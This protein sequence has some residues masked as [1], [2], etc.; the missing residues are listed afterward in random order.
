M[1]DASGG[2]N[3]N[4]TGW[5]YFTTSSSNRIIAGDDVSGLNLNIY[6]NP[7]KGIFN[8]SFVS[9]E[10]DNFEITITDAFGKMIFHED[11]QEFIGEYTQK[12]DLS[13]SPRGIYMV[14]I[15]TQGSFVSK[16][17]VLQ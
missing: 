1:C 13:N 6:P 10:V 7:T 15:K 16:R 14:Q 8:I 3:S 4:W 9:E 12:L 17:I 11:E 2:N 5:Q